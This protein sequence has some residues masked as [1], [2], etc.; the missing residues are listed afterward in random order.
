MNLSTREIRILILHE[1]RL[2]RKAI[3]ALSNISVTI[4]KDSICIDTVRRMCGDFELDDGLRSGR[5][6]EIARR[7]PG[8][9]VPKNDQ[10]KKVMFYVWGN[11]RV[12]LYELLP[13]DNN[14]KMITFYKY[15][16]FTTALVT[17]S[18][19]R[20]RIYNRLN[21]NTFE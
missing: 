16:F 9:L 17:S 5:P 15:S 20:W 13:Q 7:Q 10:F 8:I 14:K 2:G 21:I 1:F 3:D 6:T 18:R 19:Q 11:V 12:V 4:G